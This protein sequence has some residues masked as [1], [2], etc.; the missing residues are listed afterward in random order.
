MREA[1][2]IL[3]VVVFAILISTVIRSFFERLIIDKPIEVTKSK[4]ATNY[5]EIKAFY[6]N[7]LIQLRT[8]R[9]NHQQYRDSLYL[10]LETFMIK[11][12]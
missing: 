3:I 1:L 10:D 12:K 7:R 9:I 8:E 6:D 4:E 11:N 2:S 5:I